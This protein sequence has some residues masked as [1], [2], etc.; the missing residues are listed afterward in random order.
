MYHVDPD[1]L[2]FMV[3]ILMSLVTAYVSI[4]KKVMNKKSKISRLSVSNEIMMCFLAF[5]IALEIYPHIAKLLPEFITKPVFAATY[6]H[7]SSRLVIYL[8]E[9]VS[10]VFEQT[11]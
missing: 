2:S 4:V 1:A 10:K 8:E 6:V 5:L 7:M 9:K 3:S 11:N